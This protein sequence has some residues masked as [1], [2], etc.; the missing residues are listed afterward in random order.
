MSSRLGWYAGMATACEAAISG[1]AADV[2]G[3]SGTTACLARVLLAG[4][5][6]D[7]AAEA[8]ADMLKSFSEV[9]FLV[10]IGF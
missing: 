10:I 2:D 4:L 6:R 8:P 5:R 1:S 9:R 7:G 3:V